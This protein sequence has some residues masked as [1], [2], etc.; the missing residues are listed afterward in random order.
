M[1]C[2]LMTSLSPFAPVLP[3]HDLLSKQ[4]ADWR[5]SS[6][7]T[8]LLRCSHSCS[9]TSAKTHSRKPLHASPPLE[10]IKRASLPRRSLGKRFN[11]RSQAQPEEASSGSSVATDDQ[12]AKAPA[13]S[14]GQGL[15]TTKDSEEDPEGESAPDGKK[16]THRCFNDL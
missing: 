5:N 9:Y 3:C 1:A 12:N 8:P 2:S 15:T 6:Q 10:H 11:V 4:P 7:L 16:V 14:P 13:T